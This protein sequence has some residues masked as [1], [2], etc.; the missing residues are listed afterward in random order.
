MSDSFRLPR[1]G[2][3]EQPLRLAVL[4][5]GSGSGMEALLRHQAAARLAGGC[6]HQTAV[7]ISNVPDV[8]GLVKAAA[9]GI[10]AEVIQL[11]DG[12]SS[13]QRRLAHENALH[14]RLCELGIEAIILSGYMRII[15]PNFVSKWEGR[16]L[17]IHPSLLPD[18]PGAHAHRDVLKAG[19]DETG[20]TVHFVDMG[21]DSGTIISSRTVPVEPED[22][23]GSLSL[24][25]KVAEHR[26]YPMVIDAFAE[27]RIQISNGRAEIVQGPASD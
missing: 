10:P 1:I 22:D 16:L 14:D 5:S 4:I 19:V 20:C 11:P 3:D 9:H 8:S 27:G 25:V 12:S 23:E 17:N 26:L 13:S 7:V 6:C 24:R 21:V 15:T 2:S 18:F